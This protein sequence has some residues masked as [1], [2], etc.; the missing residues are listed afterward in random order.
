MKMYLEPGSVLSDRALTWQA[1]GMSLT[2]GA[3]KQNK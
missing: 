3:T 2:F 1:Q